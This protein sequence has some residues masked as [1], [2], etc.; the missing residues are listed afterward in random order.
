MEQHNIHI[1][2][3]AERIGGFCGFELENGFLLPVSPPAAASKSESGRLNRFPT[4]CEENLSCCRLRLVTLQLELHAA[5]RFCQ[6]DSL[7]VC[8]R[9][10]QLP[11]SGRSESSS[12]EDPEPPC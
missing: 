12:S 1:S 3:C 10:P 7:S 6:V 5:T 9:F 8:R 11:H 4:S 2:N